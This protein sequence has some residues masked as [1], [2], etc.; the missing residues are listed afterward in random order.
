[1]KP[2]LAVIALT[3]AALLA[4]CSKPQ[5]PEKEHPVDPQ[6]TQMRDAIQKPIEKA[7]AVEG[8]VQQGAQN[9]RDAID[10]AGG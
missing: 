7:K 2:S 10:A 8:D 9:T 1:M 4:A 5:P 6:A 3:C